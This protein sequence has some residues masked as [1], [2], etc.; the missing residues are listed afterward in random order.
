[1]HQLLTITFLCDATSVA[2]SAHSDLLASWS[3]VS[4]C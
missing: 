2:I 4:P 3:A 1:V